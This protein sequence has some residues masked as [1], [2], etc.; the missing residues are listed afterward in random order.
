MFLVAA[1]V[2]SLVLLGARRA[3]TYAIASAVASGLALT[4]A[5][6]VISIRVSFVDLALAAAIAVL[7]V[8]LLLRV[9]AKMHVVAST[10]VTAVGV[11][12]LVEV[13]L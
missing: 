6:H 1:L 9:E 10:V 7:G 12:W 13:L 2:A 5:L 4:I 11:M 3:R 8:V